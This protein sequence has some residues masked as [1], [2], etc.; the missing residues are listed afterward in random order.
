M[1]NFIVFT[2][3]KARLSRGVTLVF[4]FGDFGELGVNGLVYTTL[5][6]LPVMFGSGTYKDNNSP[7]VLYLR[8]EAAF[9]K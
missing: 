2:L 4:V 8:G 1:G 9:T 7:D 5:K 3:I 6:M